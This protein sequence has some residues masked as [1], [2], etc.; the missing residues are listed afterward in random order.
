MDL[1]TI[2]NSPKLSVTN[3]ALNWIKSLPFPGN[4]RELKNMIERTWLT[5]GKT[6]L[7][8]EDFE[9]VLEYVTVKQTVDNFPPGG[10]MTLE[11]LEKEMILKTIETYRGNMSKVAKSLG[12]SR[13]ALYRRLEKYG[14]P[15][16]K[17]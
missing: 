5:S 2:Y 7:E 13:G 8:I 16:D 14:I 3:K 12:L 11:E 9:K 1:E 15:F 4:I 17:S 6:E 10:S